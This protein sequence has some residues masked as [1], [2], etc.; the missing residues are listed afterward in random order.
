MWIEAVEPENGPPGTAITLVGFQFGH[1]QGSK[2][3]K[4]GTQTLN[5]TS[6]QNS[7]I[8]A[9]IPNNATPGTRTLT[10][11]DGMQL[12]SSSQTSFTVQ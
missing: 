5:V 9:P 2:V 7:Q 1:S 12:I 4:L 6:W 11:W 10:I 8:Q 3:L